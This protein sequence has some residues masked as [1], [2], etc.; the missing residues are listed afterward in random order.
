MRPS[1]IT[2]VELTGSRPFARSIVVT[3]SMPRPEKTGGRRTSRHCTSACAGCLPRWYVGSHALTCDEASTA[4]L[5]AV[6]ASALAPATGVTHGTSIGSDCDETTRTVLPIW[7]AATYE[8]SSVSVF[9]TLSE[10]GSE[11]SISVITDDVA[12][13]AIMRAVIAGSGSIQ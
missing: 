13:G 4:L 7:R 2:P 8:P 6:A 3:V 5:R 1:V 10:D 11:T 12:T 9:M